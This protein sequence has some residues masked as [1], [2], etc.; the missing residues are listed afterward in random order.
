MLMVEMDAKPMHLLDKLLAQK[1]QKD[2]P[3]HQTVQ[4]DNNS[5]LALKHLDH[6][7][8]RED[9]Q[10]IHGTLNHQVFNIKN[11][12]LQKLQLKR[13][14]NQLPATLTSHLLPVELP[15]KTPKDASLDTSLGCRCFSELFEWQFIII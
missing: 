10:L 15:S 5:E 8:Q 2:Q 3:L 14:L 13:Q 9:Q 4:V 1:D 11:L 7:I 12:P 6:P